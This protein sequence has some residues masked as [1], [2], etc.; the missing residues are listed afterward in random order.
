MKTEQVRNGR[1]RLSVAII[2]RN[3]QEIIAETL[4]K[5]PGDRRRDHRM[6]FRF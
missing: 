5:R 1:P 6:G 2:V 3:E 4:D